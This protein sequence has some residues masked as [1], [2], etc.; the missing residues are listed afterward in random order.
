M[1]TVNEV[2]LGVWTQQP[3]AFFEQATID[4][5][6]TLAATYGECKEGMDIS[7]KGVWGYHPLV[8]S[9]ANTASRCIW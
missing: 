9:L 7:F 4:A 8:I 1:D 5:D 6:G 2:R 3:A